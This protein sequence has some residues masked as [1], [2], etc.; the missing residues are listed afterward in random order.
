VAFGNVSALQT[1]NRFLKTLKADQSLATP[2]LRVRIDADLE[3][4]TLSV[5]DD[6]A[7]AGLQLSTVDMNIN[8]DSK[9]Q[10]NEALSIPFRVRFASGGL[11]ESF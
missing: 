5:G 10:V 6:Y 2:A 1:A 11:P 7:V 4:Q 8:G 3:L 9:Q